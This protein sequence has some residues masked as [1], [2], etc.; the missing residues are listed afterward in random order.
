MMKR[1]VKK[2][3]IGV[4]IFG[5]SACMLLLLLAL[6]VFIY[7]RTNK[8]TDEFEEISEF[9]VP[10]EDQLTRMNNL[11][12]EQAIHLEKVWRLYEIEPLDVGQVNNELEAFG[13]LNLLV[14]SQITIASQRTDMVIDLLDNKEDIVALAQL[15]AILKEIEKEQQDYHSQAFKIIRF[16][17]KDARMRVRLLQNKIED[18]EKN[19]NNSIQSMNNTVIDLKS[20]HRLVDFSPLKTNLDSVKQE[21]SDVHK[22]ALR[23]INHTSSNTKIFNVDSSRR[24]PTKRASRRKVTLDPKEEKEKLENEE[25]EV[26]KSFQLSRTTIDQV[27][28]QHHSISFSPL[29]SNIVSVKK[30]HLDVYS[31]LLGILQI[32]YEDS[33]V[34]AELLQEELQNEVDELNGKME[35]MMSQLAALTEKAANFIEAQVGKALL[36]SKSMVVF[37]TF[38]G[39]LLATIVTI[40][41]IRPVKNLL[42]STKEVEKGNL[43]I[44][45]AVKS[46]DEIGE[47]SSI[48][49]AM[50]Y[51]IRE[52]ERIK[53]TFGQYVDPRIVDDMINKGGFVENKGKREVVTIFLSDVTAFSTICEKLTPD[54]L[55]SMI[56]NYLSLASEPI[57]RYRGVI[58]KVIGDALMAYWG[59][60]FVGEQ[61]HAV[62]AC[63]AALAQFVQL[64]KLR[65]RMP[66]LMG[67]R[68][69]LPEVNIRV[70]LATGEV[71]M[72]N[73][74]SE[75]SKSYTIIGEVTKIVSNLEVLNKTYGT[76]ILI[77]EK[78]CD[79]VASAFETRKIDLINANGNQHLMLIYELLSHKGELDT[80]IV[81]MRGTFE[82]GLRLYWKQSWSKAKQHFENCLKV[83]PGDG[84]SQ[85]YLKRLEIFEK[86]P[87]GDNWDGVWESDVRI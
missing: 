10:L 68:K 46:R 14:K 87:P 60:P 61:E 81:E 71:L 27:E 62:L 25:D 23:V 26:Q 85:L 5:L 77:M 24:V 79:L 22:Q 28:N 83:K 59:P 67:I 21:H 84:P 86:N 3:P 48:F 6:S 54:R 51:D 15:K 73:I 50:V 42:E 8:I 52:K 33:K 45:V 30:N 2:I 36:F 57:N 76:S 58:D 78:T 65:K 1:F 56:N 72:G 13:K 75:N 16:I 41:L 4:K 35:A 64:D 17:K 9:L 40:G 32:L 31:Q 38:I 74:G 49:N 37:A 47:L 80:D 53:A 39:L 70:G 34:E 63:N 19:V 20:Q 66:D 11:A 55:V 69:G 12:I 18:A 44:E 82:E 29:K 43:E 7:D